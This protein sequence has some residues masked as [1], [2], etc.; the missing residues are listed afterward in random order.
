MN[1]SVILIIIMSILSYLLGSVNFAIIVTKIVLK[2]DIREHGSK[3]AGM[4]NVLRV[5]GKIP[6]L[7]TLIGDFSKGILA[8]LLTN[9]AFFIFVGDQTP[10]IVNYVVALFALL[11]HVFPVYYSFK[12]GKGVLVSFGALM[13]LNPFAGLLCFASFLIIVLVKRYVS[14]GSIVAAIFYPVAIMIVNA[15]YNRGFLTIEALYSVPISILILFMHR[16]NIRRLINHTENKI[17]LGKK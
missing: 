11:G 8:V 16:E 5:A 3:N 12:G 15:I 7:L 2:K 17:K 4:T 1:I 14:L 6:A 10:I 9:F 13:I